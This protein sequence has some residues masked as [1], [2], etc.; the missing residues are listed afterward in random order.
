MR[1]YLN[2]KR[3][4]RQTERNNRTSFRRETIVRISSN[5]LNRNIHCTCQRLEYTNV[6]WT[7]INFQCIGLLVICGEFSA[8]QIWN[9]SKLLSRVCLSS[10]FK[11]NWCSNVSRLKVDYMYSFYC[12]T[13]WFQYGREYTIFQSFSPF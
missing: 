7:N 9:M 5:D 3:I 11:E 2:A 13:L 1:A 6:A 8:N 10:L 12:W 4:T